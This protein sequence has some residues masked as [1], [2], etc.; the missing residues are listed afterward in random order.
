M[1]QN[2]PSEAW[3]KIIALVPAWNESA[4]ISAVVTHISQYLPVLVVDDGST[5]DTAKLAAAAGATVISHVAN[6]GKGKALKTGYSQALAMGYDAVL[7]LDADG[8]HDP[9][10]IPLFCEAYAAGVGEMIIGQRTFEHMPFPRWITTP[11]GAWLLSRALGIKVTDNQCGY[12]LL[13]RHCIETISLETDGFEMEVEMIWQAVKHDL[14]IAWVPVKTIYLPERKSG[15]KPVRDTRRFLKMVRRIRRER[16]A[17]D[18]EKE[19]DKT[20]SLGRLVRSFDRRQRR[21]L[22]IYEFTDDP[23]CIFRLERGE[24]PA[25]FTL[26]DGVKLKKGEKVLLLHLWSDHVPSMPSDGADLVWARKMRCMLEYSMHL[27][28]NYVSQSPAFESI[29]AVGN[30]SALP[31]SK[32]TIRLLDRLGLEVLPPLK[33]RSLYDRAAVWV[34][35]IWTWLLRKAFNPASAIDRP[36]KAFGVRPM[37]I[38]KERLL[39][40]YSKSIAG[41]A[42]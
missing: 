2:T 22:G 4:T 35:R 42:S 39:E 11:T 7:A 27:L 8:Q 10:E 36:P 40:L 9:D 12:R 3:Q 37:W 33:A 15:F 29:R 16:R 41:D 20:G 25:D 24:C 23:Q 6:Q 1:T 32:A 26:N 18:K 31:F 34:R 5:D 13:T 17:W 21:K 14:P 38:S 19:A 30:I 28:A